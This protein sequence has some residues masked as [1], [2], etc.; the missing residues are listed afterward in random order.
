MR[1]LQSSQ[2]AL[3]NMCGLSWAMWQHTFRISGSVTI[4]SKSSNS[5]LSGDWLK[6]GTS[7]W[8]DNPLPSSSQNPP[9]TLPA[10][11]PLTYRRLYA[12]TQTS[13]CNSQL[14]SQA[15]L[16]WK[17]LKTHVLSGKLFS[18]DAVDQSSSLSPVSSPDSGCHATSPSQVAGQLGVSDLDQ[19]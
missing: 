9:H 2:P 14:P 13:A 19:S 17:P 18:T 1:S 12:C 5:N 11:H 16:W 7:T 3:A 6:S 15:C 4:S 10:P 8:T